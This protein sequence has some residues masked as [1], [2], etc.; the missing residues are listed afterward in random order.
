MIGSANADKAKRKQELSAL[1]KRIHK[2]EFTIT[3]LYEDRVAEVLSED[4]FKSLIQKN[5]AERQE[6]EKRLALLESS[7]QNATAK[8]GDIEKWVCLINEKA[9]FKNVDRDLI[10]ALIE[11]IEVG[12]SRKINGVKVQD[13]RICY[14]FVGEIEQG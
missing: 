7:E 14:K 10:D 9:T 12:E 6:C 1:H 11:R 13:V 5:E 4:T 2:L 3:K 8:L